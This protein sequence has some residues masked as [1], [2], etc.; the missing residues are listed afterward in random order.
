MSR[1]R[2]GT[3]AFLILLLLLALAA[4]G[5]PYVRGAAFVLRAAGMDGAFGRALHWATAVEVDERLIAIPWR[6]GELRARAYLPRDSDGAVLVVPGVHA[7]GIDEPRL[8]DIARDLAAMR[9]TV[10]A[11]ELPP[12]LRYQITPELTDMIEDAAGW[13]AGQPTLADHEPIGI[14]GIS[15]AGG[16]SL[17]A[18]SR[19]SVRDRVA[20]ILSFGGHGDFPR[21]LEYLC[22]GIQPDGSRLPPHDY[23]VAIILLGVADRMV[24]ADQVEPLRAGI[25]TFLEGSRLDRDDR[26]AAAREFAQARRMADALP[27]PAA[28]LLGA[29]NDRDVGTLGPLL[30]PHVD[31]FGGD[32]A[33]SPARSPAPAGTVY[34]LHG[35][36]DTVIPTM[37][38]ALLADDLRARGA[39]VRHLATPLITHTDVDTAPAPREVW[40]LVRF[41]RALLAE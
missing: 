20:Y 39:R 22:T 25:L 35:A 34:L 40:R 32:P 31:E 12:L 27:E 41:W 1:P 5:W 14:A 33:L 10:V 15:F 17:V 23:G 13:L 2:R 9:R 36:G 26:E 6:G 8:A 28:S 38:S 3:Y 24:P 18:A 30:L 4:L 21:T 11:V 16:L 7:S 19:P 37:E 29:V